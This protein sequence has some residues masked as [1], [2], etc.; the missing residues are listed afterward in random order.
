MSLNSPVFGTT[1]YNYIISFVSLVSSASNKYTKSSSLQHRHTPCEQNLI[2]NGFCRKKGS[3]RQQIRNY[4]KEH[5]S[6]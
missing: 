3:G 1:F 2:S 5:I 6:C 4:N